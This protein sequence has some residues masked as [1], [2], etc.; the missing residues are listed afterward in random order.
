MQHFIKEQIIPDT[1]KENYMPYAMSVIVSRAI[2]EIDGFKPSHRKILYTM[3]K[4]GLLT[5]SRTKCANIVGQTMK[6]NPHGDAAI[7]ETLVRLTEGSE[8]LLTPF[9]DS[10]G[11]FGKIYSRDMSYAASRYTEA[12]LSSICREIF[13]EIDSD[14]VD[15]IPNYDN[16]MMEPVLLPTTFPNILAN[17]NTGIAVSMAS[18]FCSFNLVELC[19]TT[20]AF[21]KNREHDIIS[22]LPAPDFTTGGEIIVDEAQMREIYRTGRGSFKVRSKWQYIKKENIIEITE[23][24]YTTTVEAIIDKVSDLVKSGKV[25]EISDMRDETDLSGLKLAIELK[26]GTDAEKLMAKLFKMTPLMENF[27]CNFNLLINGMPKV[28]GVADILDEWSSWRAESIRRKLT[29]DVSKKREKLHLLQGLAKIL[30]DIDKA[31]KIIRDTEKDADVIPNLMSGFEI[32]AVQADFIAEIRLRHINKE[33]ILKRT[34]ETDDLIKEIKKIED[35]LSSKTKIL[36]IVIKQLESIIKKYPKERKSTIISQNNV[37][38]YKEEDHIEDYN[39]NIFLTKEGYFKKI[40]PLSLRMSGEQKLK[41]GDEMFIEMSLTNKN[42]VI[43]FTN[44]YQ[45]YKTR[46]YE[47]DDTKSSVLGEYL[48]SKLAMDEDEFPIFMFAPNDYNGHI[49]ACF[50]NGKV[51]KFDLKSFETK[52][53]RKKLTGAYS[54]K[55]PVLAFFHITE[56]AN[57]TLESTSNRALIFNTSLVSSKA[58]RSNS[59]II[60]FTLRG[61]HKVI[62]ATNNDVFGEMNDR[63]WSKVVPSIG[64]IIKTEDNEQISLL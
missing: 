8:A 9:I 40:T 7:Y 33:Y 47:F 60:V 36:N 2:P 61:K 62:S 6:L 49:V 5:G 53:N 52:T 16:K 41:D 48:P 63:Y 43:F 22:T 27:S 55:S 46:L 12:K 3:Y 39:V 50:E 51:A 15:F 32:D 25:R 14:T 59:G 30:V 28:L 24:P 64:A 19:K 45:A 54:N 57:I 35:I 37:V 23:I 38:S 44:K 34:K 18:S 31:I 11:N 42:E 17:P 56:D 21:I 1:L 4:M 29:Y 26:R 20:I 58:L 13:D 10:K